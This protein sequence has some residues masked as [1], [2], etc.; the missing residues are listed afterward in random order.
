MKYAP[1][2]YAR[3]L[4]AVIRE[5][6]IAPEAVGKRLITVAKKNGD[7][8]NLISII[9]EAER[10]IR[11]ETEVRKI[12]FETARATAPDLFEK[13]RTAFRAEDVIETSV[14]PSLL[15]GVRITINDE[16]MI[17]ATLQGRMKRLFKKN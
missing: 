8:S 16:E 17:D 4:L 13:F 5:G 1:Y 9:R 7:H 10:I 15:A 11:K 6:N 2:I 14:N 12:H 3:A